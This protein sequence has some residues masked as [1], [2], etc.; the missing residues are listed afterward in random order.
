MKVK[1]TDKFTVSFFLVVPHKICTDLMSYS[2]TVMSLCRRRCC[3]PGKQ[4]AAQSHKEKSGPSKHNGN[5][6]GFVP[7]MGGIK[8][9][10]KA[11]ES[12]GWNDMDNCFLKLLHDRDSLN[13]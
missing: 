12:R 4:C 2:C 8:R 6:Q 7:E 10:S 11:K 9:I 3:E 5:V 13:G 1:Y